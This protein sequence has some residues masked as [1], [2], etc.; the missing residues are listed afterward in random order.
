MDLKMDRVRD[1][2]SGNI[3]CSAKGAKARVVNR[4]ASTRVIT[5]TKRRDG[6]WMSAKE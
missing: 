4:D 3:C 2:K 5:L 6:L 1:D